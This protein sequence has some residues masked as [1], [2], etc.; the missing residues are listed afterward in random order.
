MAA[1]KALSD[2]ERGKIDELINTDQSDADIAAQIGRSANMVHSC[3]LRGPE[4]SPGKSSGQK[5]KLDCRDVRHIVDDVSKPGASA[6]SIKST[7]GLV[8]KDDTEGKK[9]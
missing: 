9:V 8:R 2:Y 1:G 7:L 4:N 3:Q 6:G 5:Q